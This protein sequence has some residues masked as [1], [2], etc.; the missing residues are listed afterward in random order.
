MPSDQTRP[1]TSEPSTYVQSFA[2][3]IDQDDKDQN[4]MGHVPHLVF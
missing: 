1:S 2:S 4:L 3:N